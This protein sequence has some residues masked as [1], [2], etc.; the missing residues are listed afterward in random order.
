MMAWLPFAG[1]ARESS[2]DRGSRVDR[3]RPGLPDGQDYL[4]CEPWLATTPAFAT[5]HA[6]VIRDLLRNNTAAE[7]CGIEVVSGSLIQFFRVWSG[8]KGRP[9]I[10]AR[11]RAIQPRTAMYDCRLTAVLIPCCD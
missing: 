2:S 5:L 4:I 7:P 9:P 8:P 3:G 1:T 6:L 11:W 10:Q